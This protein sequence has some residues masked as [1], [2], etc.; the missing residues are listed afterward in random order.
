MA[1]LLS[2][3]ESVA[4]AVKLAQPSFIPFS[5]SY[6]SADMAGTLSKNNINMTAFESTPSALNAA[7]G[8]SSLGKRVFVPITIDGAK[9]FYESSFQR[10][11]VVAANISQC[12]GTYTMRNDLND[13]ML[14]RDAGWIIFLASSNQE[15]LDS[16]LMSY[17]I[18]EEVLLPS[19]VNIN[20]LSLREPVSVPQERK[21]Q[22]F[23]QKPREIKLDFKKP[24]AFNAPVE[25]YMEFRSQ[26][27][28]A[29]DNALS[30]AEKAFVKWKE[31]FG[32]SYGAVEKYM[33]D[34][35]DYAFIVAG[36]NA[37]TCRAVVDRLREQGEKVGMLRI[38]MLRPF[39][40][41]NI[42]EA[43][44]S[45]KKVAVVDESISLGS[46]GIIY[47]EVVQHYHGFACDFIAGLGRYLN[48]QNF[49]DIFS[50]LKKTDT[51]E[52]VWLL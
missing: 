1:D 22:N 20:G 26:Q 11:P 17:K 4:H 52:R 49:A 38:R 35:A 51:T 16:V 29:M 14:L 45:V 7:M 41:D 48:E 36:F 28:K 47:T 34:D 40:K 5:P 24:I 31:K 13:I 19:I 43:L 6:L 9:E 46:S 10:L 21:L 37:G 32:R 12:L 2:P 33:L 8:A 39:P 27:Q 50:H 25:D 3:G 42:S 30:A 15:I 23:L 44:V 18:S